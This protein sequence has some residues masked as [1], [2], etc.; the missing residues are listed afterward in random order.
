MD[1]QES[2]QRV[3]LCRRS[4]ARRQQRSA[5]GALRPGLSGS[6]A[7]WSGAER[8]AHLQLGIVDV[9]LRRDATRTKLA[10]AHLQRVLDDVHVGIRAAVAVVRRLA[11]SRARGSCTCGRRSDTT[12]GRLSA[13]RAPTARLAAPPQRHVHSRTG[14]DA[15][16][17][18]VRGARRRYTATGSGRNALRHV[19]LRA[20]TALW[21]ASTE[22]HTMRQHASHAVREQERVEVAGDGIASE[23]ETR[24]G[25]NTNPQFEK[26][27]R[28]PAGSAL[29][30]PRTSAP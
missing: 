3:V 20:E 14:R 24:G 8:C 11:C 4:R 26:Q 18:N 6:A 13:R 19:T 21:T 17:R 7:I 15:V 30:Q 5:R 1:F 23:L 22:W 10:G 25:T 9:Q 28:G 12:A 27:Q 2:T 16:S 29:M